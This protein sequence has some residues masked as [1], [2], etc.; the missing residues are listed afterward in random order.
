MIV[1][2]VAIGARHVSAVSGLHS[3]QAQ[4]ARRRAVGQINILYLQSGKADRCKAGVWD[5]MMDALTAVHD[6]AVQMMRKVV[7]ALI[8]AMNTCF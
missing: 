5:Q 8:S 1:S 7:T 6:V 4:P 3:A 2:F